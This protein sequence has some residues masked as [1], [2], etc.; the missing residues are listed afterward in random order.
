MSVPQ[1]GCAPMRGSSCSYSAVPSNRASAQSSRG[2]CAGTQSRMTP[3]PF[4][5][6][7]STKVRKSSGVP[8]RDV[9]AK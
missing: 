6:R 9:G 8:K 4:A 5:C 3:M 7:R 1:S 2:K